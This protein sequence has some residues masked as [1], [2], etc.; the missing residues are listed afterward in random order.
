MKLRIK[1]KNNK[2]KVLKVVLGYK[3]HVFK[4]GDFVKHNIDNTIGKIASISDY[5]IVLW[6]DGYKERIKT[7][8]LRKI[9][10]YVDY[11]EEVIQ[12][13]NT[14]TNMDSKTNTFTKQVY[15]IEKQNKEQENK[16]IEVKDDLDDIYSSILNDNDNFDDIEDGSVDDIRFTK[17]DTIEDINPEK[18]QDVKNKAIDEVI[19]VMKNKGMITSDEVEKTQR[20]IISKMDDDGFEKFKNVILNKKPEQKPVEKTEAELIL[21]KIKSGGPIIGDFS[22]FS[23]SS[24]VDID[25]NSETRS[26]SGRQNKPLD[27]SMNDTMEN[28]I[29]NLSKSNLSVDEDNIVSENKE[30]ERKLNFDGFKNIQGL[31]KPIQIQNNQNTPRGNFIEAI[32]NIDWTIFTK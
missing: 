14:Q 32:N 4:E 12:P 9:V 26:L 15:N 5:A 21:E 3:S 20:D 23:E 11:V 10:S 8:D 1:V 13:M 16:P 7:A 2:R 24:H 29:N 30:P 18:I 22:K 28:I 27:P 6:N 17:E 31:K 19:H 25:D